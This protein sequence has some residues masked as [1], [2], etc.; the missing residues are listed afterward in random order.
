MMLGLLLARAG[1][2]VVVLEKHHD[3]LRDF[4]GDTVHAS[5]IRVMDE[6]GIGERFLALPHQKITELKVEVDGE[7]MTL[8]DFGGL[9][10][11]HR[12][13]AFMPQ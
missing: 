9:P 12:Y 5:T 8:A 6:L 1:I 4:R 13:I 3:F 7:V 10:G 11:R 2:E